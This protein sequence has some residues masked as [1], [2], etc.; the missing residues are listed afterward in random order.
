MNNLAEAF[1]KILETQL[2]KF[3]I[4]CEEISGK[5]IYREAGHGNLQQE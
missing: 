3:N 4:N 2:S 1:F 5:I